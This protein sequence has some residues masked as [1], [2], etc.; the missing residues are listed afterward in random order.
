MSKTY[1]VRPD[2]YRD[3]LRPRGFGYEVLMGEHHPR[4]HELLQNWAELAET[5]DILVRNAG[6][7][8][9]SL[10][11]AALELFQY[12]SGFGMGIAEPLR[13]FV[14]YECLVEVDAPT[15]LAEE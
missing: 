7:E 12:A 15:A 3:L 10:D 1:R 5:I 14:L 9:G 11:E 6:R 8:F 2:A 4:K 13:D